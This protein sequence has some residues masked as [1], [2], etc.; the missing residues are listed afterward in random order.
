VLEP[1]TL[2]RAFSTPTTMPESPGTQW[3]KLKRYL[4]ALN[5]S[6]EGAPRIALPTTADTIAPILP[7]TLAWLQRFFDHSGGTGT[8]DTQG[9][10]GQAGDGPWLVTAYPRAGSPAY[11]T[12]DSAGR[13]QYDQLLEDKWA[14]IYRYFIRPYGRYDLLW[15]SLRQSPLLFPNQHDRL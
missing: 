13:L 7:E 14:H 2:A 11:A 5:S 15:G 4:E 8:T 1:E 6:E 9:H 3:L 10:P 12:P